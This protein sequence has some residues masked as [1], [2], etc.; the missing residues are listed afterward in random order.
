M[1]K[2]MNG[3]SRGLSA[4]V[5]AFALAA[6][7]IPTVAAEH[8]V[9]KVS[10]GGFARTVERLE[11][12]IKKRGMMVVAT[13]DHQNMLRVVGASIRGSK[14]LE[15]AKPDMMKGILPN[16]PAVGLEMPLKIYVYERA[17]G[18]AVLSYYKPSGGFSG[19]G[20]E[21]LTKAG[22]MMDMMLAEIVAEAAK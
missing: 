2:T 18:K 17:D 14:A 15:F 3:F 8:R 9:E 16:D 21:G 22:Q 10:G 20:K 19:Y 6:F 7:S 12:A 13:L 5:A 11:T 1:R 4:F